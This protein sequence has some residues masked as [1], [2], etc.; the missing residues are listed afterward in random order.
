[1]TSRTNRRI[2]DKNPANRC[3]LVEATEQLLREEGHA[4]TSARKV[5]QKAGLTPQL[6]N[7]TFGRWMTSS[8]P[9]MGK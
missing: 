4:A 6:S 9:F 5:A 2:G 7:I 8:S 3:V 1:M